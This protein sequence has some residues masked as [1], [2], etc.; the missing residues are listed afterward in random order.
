M[1]AIRTAFLAVFCLFPGLLWAQDVRLATPDG[2]LGV[3]GRLLDFDGEVY[4]VDTIYGPMTVDASRVTCDG[5]GCPDPA[6]FSPEVVLSGSPSLAGLLLPALIE[7]YAAR[8]GYATARR[9]ASDRDFS[10]ELSDPATGRPVVRFLFRVSGDAEGLADLL[11]GEADIALAAREIRPD[12]A[13][14]TREAGLGDLTEPSQG[15]ILALDALVPVTGLGNPVSTITMSDLAR[16]LTGELRTWDALGGPNAPV[17]LHGLLPGVGEAEAL[18]ARVPGV[19]PGAAMP[20]IAL[21][22]DLAELTDAV[23]RAPNA[24]G[25]TAFSELGSARMLAIAG[26]CGIEARASVAS[27]K[28]EDYPL[29][30]PL[31]AY[32]PRKRLPAPVRAFL[33]YATSPG[34]A[35]VVRRAGFVD[36]RPEALDIVGQG[37]R[38]A[39][40]IRSAGGDTSLDDLQGMMDAL[41]GA[42]RLTVTF[43]FE[44]GS[45]RL[46]AQSRGNV[47][48]LADEIARGAFR[49]RDL[50]LAGFTDAVGPAAVNRRLSVER[51]RSVRDAIAA[52]LAERGTEAAFEVLGFGEALPMACDDVG[53]GQRINRRVEVWVR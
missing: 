48:L 3:S 34:A 32:L 25:L 43:R 23:A 37:D 38:L 6:T 36:Q 41:S 11:A 17:E 14:R 47:G 5:D 4:R 49:G 26:P 12:E 46:D 19:G 2:G 45:S 13:R 7:G 10:Y 50:I 16:A 39:N 20:G 29:S 42:D 53:W 31:F 52:A 35:L 44:T 30:Y 28:A 33:R 27:L 22:S 24:L 18:L 8:E 51:A 15:L 9:M 1:S 40:A 21:H